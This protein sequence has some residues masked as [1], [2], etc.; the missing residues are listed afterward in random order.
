MA[1]IKH[2]YWQQGQTYG[3]LERPRGIGFTSRPSKPYILVTNDSENWVAKRLGN[4]HTWHD[5]IHPLEAAG[6]TVRAKAGSRTTLQVEWRLPLEWAAKAIRKRD[7]EQPAGAADYEI[8][9]A[10]QKLVDTVLREVKQASIPET[11]VIQYV[12]WE[13]VRKKSAHSLDAIHR[14]LEKAYDETLTHWNWVWLNLRIKFHMSGPAF[15]LAYSP[16]RG[17]HIIS[18][19]ARMLGAYTL[20]SIYRTIVHELCHHYREERFPR[21]IDPHDKQ[22]CDELAKIDRTISGDPR[23]CRHFVDVADP[24]LQARVPGRKK[25]LPVWDEKA[26]TFQVWHKK[27]GT[28]SLYWTPNKGYSWATWRIGLSAEGMVDILKQFSPSEWSKVVMKLHPK[29]AEEWWYRN[30][31]AGPVSLSFFTARIISA[32]PRAM[33]PLADYLRETVARGFEESS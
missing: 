18:L 10:A 20:D 24:A 11:K 27:S 33:K 26:G 2:W 6:I 21:S 23:A 3:I 8:Q 5:V 7:R 15:G 30:I 31:S 25:R 29:S 16:G 9:A 4:H 28:F 32:F 1:K 17:D 14:L 19:N 13:T 12:G 22:F